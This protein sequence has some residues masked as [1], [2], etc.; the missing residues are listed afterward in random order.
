MTTKRVAG[1]DKRHVPARQP[2]AR[3]RSGPT[4]AVKPG[5][6]ASGSKERF[7]GKHLFDRAKVSSKGWIVIPKEIRDEMDH[8]V[9]A[10]RW[11]WRSGRHPR[12]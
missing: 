3:K 9:L 10:T 5:E 12:T 8:C 6:I 2:A 11:R 4:R 7:F 1:T